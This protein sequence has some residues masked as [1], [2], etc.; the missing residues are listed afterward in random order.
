MSVG[1]IQNFLNS[2]VPTCDS[3]GT[4]PYAGTTRRAYSESKGIKFP[5]TCVKDYYENPVTHE[6]NLSGNP[7]PSNA[8]GAAQIIWDASQQYNINPQVLLVLLQKE[9]ALTLDDW[10]WP[11]QFQG[12]TGYGCPDTAA[13][14]TQYYG[15]YNQIMN[16]ARQFRLYAN[17]PNQYNYVPGINNYIRYNPNSSCGGSNVFI[18]NQATAS[19]YN[20]TPYQPN[21]SA[22]NNLYGSGDSCGAYGNRNFWRYFNDWFGTSLTGTQPSPLYKSDTNA[23]IYA[24]SGNMKYPIPSWDVMQNYGYQ[25]YP[26]AIVSD[27]FLSNY[28]TGAALTSMAKKSNDPGGTIYFFDDDKRYPVDISACKTLPD[29]STNASTTWGLDCFN[30]NNTL[31]LPNELIDRYTVQ[32]IT[33]PRLVMNGT[34]AWDMENGAKRRIVS[35]IFGDVL[36]GWSSARWMQDMHVA[37]PEGR[38]LITNGSAVKFDNNSA[39]YLVSNDQLYA[40]GSANEFNEWNLGG[41]AYH[42]LPGSYN[43]SSPIPVS[44]SSLSYCASDSSGRYYLLTLDARRVLLTGDPG[45]WPANTSNCNT[46]MDYALPAIPGTSNTGPY[47]S[48]NGGIFTVYAG[49]VYFFPTLDDFK[50]LG[51]NVSQILNVSSATLSN[52]TYGGL[53]LAPGRLFKVQGN[54]TIRLVTNSTSLVV[55]AANYPGL[56]YGSLIT[57]D[58]MAG[59]RYPISG[60]YTP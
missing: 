10:P 55:N 20:Y 44:S 42:Y 57:V 17:S 5:L 32:D 51:N 30:G 9:Q 39:I 48:D 50:N 38:L 43:T 11:I 14:D 60:T 7:M 13:C 47:R 6:N 3:W 56:P 49:K 24:V 33:L 15:F 4:Q 21:Q 26:V 52:L 2:K 25:R 22:L 12:A 41:R 18:E 54:D 34:A 19:L 35:P 53:H 45:N 58:A 36:G 1:Q 29:G 23:T 59:A 27:T 37:Q 16:A 28:T 8:K 31:S 46:S 40:A